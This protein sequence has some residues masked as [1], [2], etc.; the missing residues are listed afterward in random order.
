MTTA[1]GVFPSIQYLV[2]GGRFLVVGSRASVEM[3]DLGVAGGPPL[4]PP[5]LVASTPI[6]ISREHSP[7]PVQEVLEIVV[8]SCGSDGNGL[9]IAVRGRDVDWDPLCV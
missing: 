3:W 9:R 6:F 4:E 1:D 2:P 7:K 8:C 5:R